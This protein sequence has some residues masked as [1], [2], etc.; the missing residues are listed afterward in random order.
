MGAETKILLLLF[1][2]MCIYALVGFWLKR[3]GR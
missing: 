3:R 1:G 2:V